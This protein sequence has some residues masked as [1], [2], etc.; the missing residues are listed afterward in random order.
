MAVAK[1]QG[2]PTGQGE[3]DSQHHKARVRKQITKHLKEAIGGEDIITAPADGKIRV[4]VK[5]SKRFQFIYDRGKGNG[6]GGSG[7]GDGPGGNGAG[8][9]PGAEDY[10]VWLDQK[11]MEDMLFAELA[12]P[13]LKP[14]KET[15]AEVSDIRFDTIAIKGPQIDKKATMRRHL[16]RTSATGDEDFEKDDL[17]YMS[18]REKPRPKSKAV[19]FMAMDVS[20]S[21]GP[22]EKQIARLFFYWTVRFLRYRYDTVDVRF[23]SHTSEA[24]EVTEHEFFNRAES[25]GTMVSSAYQL[26][27]RMQK[28]Q[29]PTDDWNIY[30]LHASDGDN[31]EIDNKEVYESIQRLCKVSS[32]VGYLEIAHQAGS[33]MNWGQSV[34]SSALTNM[35]K[36]KGSPG[37]EFLTSRVENE[38][39]I[40]GALKYFFAKEE[41]D[42]A[43]KP[44]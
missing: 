39:E 41:V 17:R 3:R 27:E 9:E 16:L 32:L 26:V 43:V 7:D 38:R 12:L 44:S 6:G 36:A 8:T 40:W 1:R 15:D 18:Y 37:P 23:I 29:Y 25:G 13:R 4:P 34:R 31:W 28:N 10:E 30:V 35:L 5:G 11:E 21:M 20:G 2:I 24:R 19:V 42:T 22:H 33:W 14:K